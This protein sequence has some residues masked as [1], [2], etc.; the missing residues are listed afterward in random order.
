MFNQVV[1]FIFAEQQQTC[2][3]SIVIMG[4]FEIVLENTIMNQI[5]KDKGIIYRIS[6]RYGNVMFDI[7][8]VYVVGRT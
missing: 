5:I 3:Q 6:S 1:R 7:N 4:I 8:H 2:N